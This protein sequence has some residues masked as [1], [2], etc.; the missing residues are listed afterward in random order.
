[1]EV[2]LNGY[3]NEGSHQL[4]IVLSWNQLHIIVIQVLPLIPKRAS[5]VSSFSM[6]E[7]S[8]L[9]EIGPPPDALESFR[10]LER[11]VPPI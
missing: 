8:F 2:G 11:L 10:I 3:F 4:L 7:E 9:L 5:Q 1:M 6:Y